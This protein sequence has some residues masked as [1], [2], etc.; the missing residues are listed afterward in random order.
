MDTA[1]VIE[2]LN[3]AVALE[4]AT[5]N[6]ARK[7]LATYDRYHRSVFLTPPWPEIYVTDKQRRHALAEAIGEY[8]RLLVAY[9]LLGYDTIIL[10]K[11]AVG[12]R[13][14]FVLR[15]LC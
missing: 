1:R 14:D 15:H 6:P 8:D 12:D 9:R 11:V 13:A 4:H 7:L 2:A 3:T 5:G 10:P